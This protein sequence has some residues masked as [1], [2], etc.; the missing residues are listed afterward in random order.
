MAST[1][2]IK[3]KVGS[4]PE[5]YTLNQHQDTRVLDSQQVVRM[6]GGRKLPMKNTSIVLM[7]LTI[8]G[9]CYMAPCSRHI[10]VE[11]EIRDQ[12]GELYKNECELFIIDDVEKWE[13]PWSEI[14]TEKFSTNISIA[15]SGK[16]YVL[17]LECEG[18]KY[19]KTE[20]F[21]ADDYS[22]FP[23]EMGV[24]KLEPES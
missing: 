1:L 2:L 9:C 24:I 18:Y 7:A 13:A 22:V 6:C 5:I 3:I 11:G 14:V 15:P 23:Y 20:I 10:S 19:H 21:L 4:V 8:S 16:K 17:Q 12:N